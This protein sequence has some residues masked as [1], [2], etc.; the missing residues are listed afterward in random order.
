ME[1][2]QRRKRTQAAHDAD[3]GR[4]LAGAV[5]DSEMIAGTHDALSLLASKWKV[6]VLYL[7]ATGARRYS[8][9]HRQLPVSKKVLT[10]TL[11]AMERDGLVRRRI[12]AEVP[13]RVEYSLTPL[14]WSLT[15]VLMTMFE[16]ASEHFGAVEE[17]RRAHAEKDAAV[18]ALAWLPRAADPEP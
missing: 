13:V 2:A 6:D 12:F 14:G 4:S 1:T 3:G 11:R 5:R 7:L 18:A 17:A 10:E 8:G 16:W 15:E 9:L